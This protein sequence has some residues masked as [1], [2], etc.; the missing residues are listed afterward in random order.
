MN[1][2]APLENLTDRLVVLL[3]IRGSPPE[4]GDTVHETVVLCVRQRS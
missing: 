2:T 3:Q 1:G 4:M